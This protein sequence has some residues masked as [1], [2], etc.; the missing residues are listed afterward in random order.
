M[1]FDEGRAPHEAYHN[2]YAMLMA[3]ASRKGYL[4][5]RPGHRPFLLSRSGSTGSQRFTAHW[6]GDNWSNYHHLHI[7]IGKSLNLALSGFAH[8][9]ADVGGFGGNCREPLFVDWYKAAFLFPFFR[10]HSMRTS[11]GQEPWRYSREAMSTVRRLV[12]LRYKLLP[13]L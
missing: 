7:S 11:H 9:G 4:R 6:T 13:Y 8:N 2:Q 5:A 3:E 12:R 10:N 1:L